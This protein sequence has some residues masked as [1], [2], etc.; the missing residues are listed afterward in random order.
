MCANLPSVEIGYVTP[1][2]GRGVRDTKE[3]RDGCQ[4][5]K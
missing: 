3:Q 1:E 5:G 4:E 2:V